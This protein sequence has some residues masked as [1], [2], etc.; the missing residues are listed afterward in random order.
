MGKHEKQTD[1]NTVPYNEHADPVHNAQEFDEQ[2]EQNR[3]Y[4]DTPNADAAGVDRSHGK[5]AK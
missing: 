4:T 5:H 1:W 3:T 2:Y